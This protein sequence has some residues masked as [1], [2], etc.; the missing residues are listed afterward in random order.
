MRHLISLFILLLFI[1]LIWSYSG[2]NM[3]LS[4]AKAHIS[5]VQEINPSDSLNRNV[6]GIQP[7]M[8]VSDYF[9]QV[10]YKDKLRFY[11]AESKLKGFLNKNTIVLFPEYIG[12]WLVLEGEKHVLAKKETM[13]EALTTMVW[14]NSSGL[15]AV[16]K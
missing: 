6:V 4:E 16:V 13:K 12:T 15:M 8:D 2:R 10:K 3:P 14:S 11:L 7:Y 9:S 5:M 1:W